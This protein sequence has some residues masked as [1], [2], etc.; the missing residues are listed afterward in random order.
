MTKIVDDIIKASG[1]IPPVDRTQRTLTDGSPVTDDHRELRAD[2]QQKG[3][4]VLSDAERA[5]GFVRSV[6]QSY[7]H[8]KCGRPTKMGLSLAETYARDPQFYSGTFCVHCGGHFPV[9]P[10]GEFVWE[11]T[12]EK[13]G[14]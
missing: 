6:R 4:I 3:Y 9:G 7:V 1:A 13:V 8:L 10:S 2:G 11:G 5:R 12:D 14:T